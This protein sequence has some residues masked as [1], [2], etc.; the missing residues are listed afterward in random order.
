M[1]VS[2][3]LNFKL[4]IF[5][6]VVPFQSENEFFLRLFV[7]DKHF[8][9]R[10]SENKT[11]I[12]CRSK[13]CSTFKRQTYSFYSGWRLWYMYPIPPSYDQK[14]TDL[15]LITIPKIVLAPQCSLAYP[16]LLKTYETYVLKKANKTSIRYGVQM[17]V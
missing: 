1:K 6:Q 17:K 8:L 10:K 4:E 12:T 11:E 16:S 5:R 9:T 14:S 15:Q 13:P 2:N 7:M 3:N